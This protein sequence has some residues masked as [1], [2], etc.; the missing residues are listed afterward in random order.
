MIIIKC[1]VFFK[2]GEDTAK[3]SVN[4]SISSGV[5]VGGG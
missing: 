1:L 4:E 5:G 2:R 3:Y